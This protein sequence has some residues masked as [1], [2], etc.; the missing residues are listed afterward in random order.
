MSLVATNTLGQHTP[1]TAAVEASYGEM[2]AQDARAMYGYADESAIASRLA[3]FSPPLISRAAGLTLS[4]S[5]PVRALHR[6]PMWPDIEAN[7]GQAV[8]LGALSV[9][10]TWVKAAEAC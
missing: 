6:P 3:P 10:R 9:P 4:S 2:W 7:A 8:P 1:S 5:E